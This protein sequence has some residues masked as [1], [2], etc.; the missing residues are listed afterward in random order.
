MQKSMEHRHRFILQFQEFVLP[1]KQKCIN[2]TRNDFHTF[3]Q[4]YKDSQKEYTIYKVHFCSRP[5]SERNVGPVW[6]SNF[7][8]RSFSGRLGKVGRVDRVSIWLISDR[9]IRETI[10]LPLLSSKA[11]AAEFKASSLHRAK[12]KT[13]VDTN[14]HLANDAFIFLRKTQKCTQKLLNLPKEPRLHYVAQRMRVSLWILDQSMYIY[15][16][17]VYTPSFSRKRT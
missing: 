16:T 4:E 2:K 5:D 1:H 15:V 9:L 13:E 7:G 3:S 10:K 11:L 6:T 8:G 17:T 14:R 12:Q